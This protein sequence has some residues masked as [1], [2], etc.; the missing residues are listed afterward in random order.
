MLQEAPWWEVWLHQ[1]NGKQGYI[2][3]FMYHESY[4]I[5]DT[6]QLLDMKR[7]EICEYCVF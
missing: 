2:S 3:V 7:E 1:E 4:E 6:F 5:D